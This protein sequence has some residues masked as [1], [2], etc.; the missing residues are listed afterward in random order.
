MTATAEELI[1]YA[2]VSPPSANNVRRYIWAKVGTQNA[3]KDITELEGS[4]A[5]TEQQLCSFI[6]LA[7]EHWSMVSGTGWD[8]SVRFLPSN[9]TTISEYKKNLNRD[10]ALL[11]RG[12]WFEKGMQIAVRYTARY[13]DDTEYRIPRS[14]PSKPTKPWQGSVATQS[15]VLLPSPLP[16]RR[17]RLN[18]RKSHPHQ[19]ADDRPSSKRS[20]A[21]E[22]S[23]DS[24]PTPPS[25]MSSES[26]LAVQLTDH[27]ASGYHVPSD[28]HRG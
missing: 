20:R 1:N 24:E 8:P 5:K 28:R 23:T 2:T 13:L 27:S 11:N 4:L 10:E 3:P 9:S 26:C 12:T 6:T 21:S 14:E 18:K 7:K 22:S 15:L 17:L 16:F 25:R 19:Q